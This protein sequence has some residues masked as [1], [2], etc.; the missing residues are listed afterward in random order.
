MMPQT[1]NGLEFRVLGP[2]EV[3]DGPRTLDL[4][5]YKQ[6]RVLALLLANANNTV[7]TDQIVDVLWGDE[8]DV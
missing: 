3:L 5:P 4:G 8:T 6:R 7:A 2:L 1:G